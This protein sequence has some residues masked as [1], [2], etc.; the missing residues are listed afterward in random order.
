MVSYR[1]AQP[2]SAEDNV[3]EMFLR[4]VGKKQIHGMSL[5]NELSAALQRTR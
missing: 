5:N 1:S 3:T 4:S 2:N